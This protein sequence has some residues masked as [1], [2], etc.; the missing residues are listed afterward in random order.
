MDIKDAIKYASIEQDKFEKEVSSKLMQTFFSNIVIK[1]IPLDSQKEAEKFNDERVKDTISEV[2][3]EKVKNYF[4]DFYSGKLENSNV[5]TLFDDMAKCVVSSVK[6]ESEKRYE[7][8][9]DDIENGKIN[10]DE[11]VSTKMAIES[12]FEV[13][14]N[15]LDNFKNKLV[16]ENFINTSRALLSLEAEDTIE[17]VKEEVSDSIQKADEKNKAVQLTLKAL[18]DEKEEDKEELEKELEEDKDTEEPSEENN[19]VD[20][21]SEESDEDTADEG[22][23]TDESVEEEASADETG[24]QEDITQDENAIDEKT[25]T[26]SENFENDESEMSENNQE[27]ENFDNDVGSSGTEEQQ[28]TP[29]QNP[30]T[31]SNVVTPKSSD[32]V[33]Q[34]IVPTE[35]K[36]VESFKPYNTKKIVEELLKYGG[37]IEEEFKIRKLMLKNL[38][39]LESSDI[40]KNKHDVIV[41]NAEKVR[42][43][44]N[45]YES[46][47]DVLGFNPRAIFDKKNAFTVECAKEI[48]RR[49][50]SKKNRKTVTLESFEDV[51]I[52]TP[53]KLVNYL[54]NLNQFKKQ[55][56]NKKMPSVVYDKFVSYESV[57][58]KSIDG[59]DQDTVEK[60]KAL[61][62]IH[63]LD[64]SNVMNTKDFKNSLFEVVNKNDFENKGEF[65]NIEMVDKIVSRVSEYMNKSGNTKTFNEG[66]LEELIKSVINNNDV[67]EIFPT[68]YEKFII[69]VGNRTIRMSEESCSEFGAINFNSI[70]RKA[71]LLTTLYVASKHFNLID[72]NDEKFINQL[73]F[74]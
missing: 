40:I 19:T 38:V 74:V 60:I 69:S 31:G 3:E 2:V 66:E 39:T 30:V 13:A 68:V 72:K 22:S 12:Y 52:N 17:A 14:N 43:L 61:G 10:T 15:N 58:L 4:S 49:Y 67:T 37:N 27:Q 51:D 9:V 57:L 21:G 7:K 28:E 46:R 25:E 47:F 23:E 70:E 29:V 34:M 56:K 32:I 36:S 71:R 59:M 20:E 33:I 5:R 16:R 50:V 54:F 41:E 65:K 11:D 42:N 55:F 64:L 53:K 8:L 73:S 45:H 24:E 6:E 18:K 63:E 44:Y 35:R 48:Y 62:D 1:S 26:D